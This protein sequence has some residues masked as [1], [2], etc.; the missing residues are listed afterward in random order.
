MV[1]VIEILPTDHQHQT[2]DDDSKHHSKTNGNGHIIE[3]N[4]DFHD[5]VEKTTPLIRD[6]V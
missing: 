6:N 2:T 1:E 4:N 5:A 3:M